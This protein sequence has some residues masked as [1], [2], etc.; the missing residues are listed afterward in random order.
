MAAEAMNS[1]YSNITDLTAAVNPTASINRIEEEG[2]LYNYT[3]N[4][5]IGNDIN[6]VINYPETSQMS[7]N[8]CLFN[9][10]QTDLNVFT[11]SAIGQEDPQ[12]LKCPFENTSVYSMIT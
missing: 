7:R 5:A 9:H 1:V 2:R 8:E 11:K 10:Y 3:N 4:P 6:Q 12:I